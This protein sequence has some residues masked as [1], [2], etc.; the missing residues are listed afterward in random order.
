MLATGLSNTLYISF[1]PA[2]IFMG[3]YVIYSRLIKT[4]EKD[5]SWIYPSVEF[6][7]FQEGGLSPALL[8]TLNLIKRT[9]KKSVSPNEWQLADLHHSTGGPPE[10]LTLGDGQVITSCLWLFS[11]RLSPVF[12][13]NYLPLKALRASLVVPHHKFD[14][15]CFFF[16]ILPSCFIIFLEMFHFKRR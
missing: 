12:I 2:A 10:F 5:G 6:E 14:L 13:V 15:H 8:P 1:P 4:V 9:T 11:T 16:F 7:H 3:V